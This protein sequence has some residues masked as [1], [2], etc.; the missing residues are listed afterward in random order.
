MLANDSF[1][2]ALSFFNCVLHVRKLHVLL[3][4]T[5]QT[6]LPLKW[7]KTSLRKTLS[8]MKVIFDNNANESP[9]L[10]RSPSLLKH[11]AQKSE[12]AGQ[13]EQIFSE[14]VLANECGPPLAVIVVRRKTQNDREEEVENL[15]V[16]ATHSAI[17]MSWSP[18]YMKSTLDKSRADTAS[19]PTNNLLVQ[20]I[21]DNFGGSNENKTNSNT[22]QQSDSERE[23]SWP[24]ADWQQI[25]KNL[26]AH[27]GMNA[28]T[29]DMYSSP[30][31]R[32]PSLKG[33]N[34]QSK[35][36]PNATAKCHI[37]R[38]T[39]TLSIVAVQGSSPRTKPR[40]VSNLEESLSK[41]ALRFRPENII[42]ASSVL[43]AKTS[44][45]PRFNNER[46]EHSKKRP[47]VSALWSAAGW[48][49][50]Q[51]KQVL[52]SLGLRSKHSPVVS[53]P[54][55][56]PYVRRQMSRMRQRK[57]KKK[58]SL[59]TGHLLMFLGPELSHLI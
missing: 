43:L 10:S 38:I 44:V 6:S 2:L 9:L 13:L 30:N 32:T 45:A 57:K 5:A 14:F 49:D 28:R 54:L 59:N 22:I 19:A 41:L 31:K 33:K 37:V 7:M 4:R 36:R 50:V 20:M 29:Y 56:S 46:G 25:E 23:I 11:R 1:S 42:S 35:A 39:E 15:P 17:S 47:E 55:K 53:A 21:R 3:G 18:L 8:M 34:N 48:S 12:E 58:N 16:G 24:F 27:T 51:R 52:H 40:Q 26:T